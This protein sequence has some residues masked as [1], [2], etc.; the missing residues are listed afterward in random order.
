VSPQQ[1][2]AQ[3]VEDLLVCVRAVSIDRFSHGFTDLI[4][5]GSIT[6]LYNSYTIE[7]G[8]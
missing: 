8:I 3:D 7:F 6:I 1:P 4:F 5:S 2:S